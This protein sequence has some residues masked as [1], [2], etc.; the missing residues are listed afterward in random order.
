MNSNPSNPSANGGKTINIADILALP[1]RQRQIVLF[2]RREEGHTLPEIADHLNEDEQAIAIELDELVQEGFVREIQV[3]GIPRYYRSEMRRQGSQFSEMIQQALTPGKPLSMIVNPSGDAP[4]TPGLTFE[5]CVTI[6]NEGNQSALIDI[7]IDETSQFLHQ[8]CISPYERLALGRG[9]SSEVV[10][11]IPVPL[12]AIPGTY[13]YLL[14]V[15]AQQHYPQDTPIQHQARLQVLPFVQ[16]A[17]RVNDPTF[18]LLPL[19]NSAAPAVVQPGEFLEVQVLVHN[20]SDRVDQFRLTCPDLAPNWY[21]VI[22]PEGYTQAGVVRVMD[23]LELN[24]GEKGQIQL[25]ITPPVD[26][27]ASIYSPTVRLYSL[28][29]PDLVL[30]DVIYLQVM[31][32]YLLTVEL[33][34]LVGKISNQS[35]VF[36]LQLY[37]GGNITRDIALIAKSADGDDLCTYTLIPSQVRLAPGGYAIANLD[38]Q[39]SQKWWR[40]PFYGR[41]LNFVIEIEDRQQ[42][43]LINNRFQ[44]TLIWEGRPWWQFLLVIL[45]IV[46]LIGAL[47]FLLWFLFF[48]PKPRPEIVEFAPAS[49]NYSAAEGESV[50]LNWEINNP[51]RIQMIKVQGVSPEGVVTSSPIAYNFSQGIPNELERFCTINEVLNCQNVPTDAREPGDYV[52][53][54]TVIPQGKKRGES[55]ELLTNTVKITPFPIPEIEEFTSTQAV[56]QQAS[57]RTPEAANQEASPTANDDNSPPNQ[58]QPENRVIVLN[59]KISHPEQIRL[60]KLVGRN[61]E[62]IILVPMQSIDFSQGIPQGLQ[63]AC[64]IKDETLVCANI[65]ID[66]PQPGTYIFELI[67]VPRQGEPEELPAQKTD[68]IKIEAQPVPFNIVEFTVGGVETLTRPKFVVPISGNQ[69]IPVPLSW[70]VE[71]GRDLKVELL[72]APGTVPPEGTLPYELSPEPTTETITLQVT[73]EAGEQKSRSV[74]IETIQPPPPE[75]PAMTL[76]PPPSPPGDATNGLP[77]LPPLPPP[78]G[79]SASPMQTPPSP[80]PSPSPS[81]RTTPS[82]TE[83]KPLRLPLGGSPPLPPGADSPPPAE[84]PPKFR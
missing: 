12:D 10:F 80:S 24:P 84:L 37:N 44:G 25:I 55:E 1:E 11:Q 47:I 35:G 59:W 53:E 48:R 61:P 66:N 19:T 64:E 62:G 76:S 74:T 14:I 49:N 32:I 4:I 57:Q 65:P 60:L 41:V 13:N 45:G 75:P 81:P 67:V 16:E 2:I 50:R 28:N 71:G 40:R 21:R 20:R 54:L 77:I 39:P 3:E 8:W 63:E 79:A 33:V 7:Y 5:L 69:S 56:Y 30:L 78:G 73:N 9:Q 17:I 70:K 22:Y 83:P 34:T 82:E 42:F 27:W 51:E 72:P 43:P 52:F 18:T 31:P 68:P 23:G 58:P 29:N 36:E 6:T 26:T 15:D 38:V 46:G